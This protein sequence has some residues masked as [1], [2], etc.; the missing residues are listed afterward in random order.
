VTLV[1]THNGMNTAGEVY[2]LECYVNG[3][4]SSMSFQWLDSHGTAVI[5][6]HSVAITKSALQSQLQFSPLRQSHTGTYACTAIAS[7]GGST[8][9]KSTH[10][11]VNGMFFLFV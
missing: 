5:N 8:E 1:V 11:K 6:N 9:S 7:S 4:N 10:V 3:T 2:I